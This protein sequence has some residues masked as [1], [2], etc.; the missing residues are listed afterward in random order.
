MPFKWRR[1]WFKE[2]YGSYRG[3]ADRRFMGRC[4]KLAALHQ[5][6]KIDTG[7]SKRK[8]HHTGKAGRPPLAQ[9]L[10]KELFRWFAGLRK[11]VKGRFPSKLLKQ[12]AEHLRHCAL[13]EAARLNVHVSLPEITSK[14]LTK[15]KK[16]FR[17]SLRKPCTFFKVP[18]NVFLERC[19][20]C[21]SNVYRARLFIM[22]HCGYD[23]EIEG[24]DQTPFHF[25]ESGSKSKA[26]LDFKGKKK[27]TLKECVSASRDRWTATTYT[28]SNPAGHPVPLEA[29]F[30]GG[31]GVLQSVQETLEAL[32]ASGRFGSLQNV[33]VNTSSSGSYTLPDVLAFLQRHLEP[34]TKNRRWKIL[35]CDAYKPH[36]CK[37]VRDLCWSRGYL[38]V[39][40]GG[41]C[42]G[43]QQVN[44]THLH[45][46]MSRT[47]Q[48][49][50][51]ELFIFAQEANP[52]G[53]KTMKREDCLRLLLIT[54]E[55]KSL[56]EDAS[57]GYQQ[58]LFTLP[59]DR[60][61]PDQVDFSAGSQQAQEIFRLCGMPEEVAV[62]THDLDD[63]F[64]AGRRPFTREAFE[65][66][67][68]EMPKRGHMDE[69]EDEFI[70]EG[71]A[72]KE[73]I[74]LWNDVQESESQHEEDETPQL[75]QSSVQAGFEKK[76]ISQLDASQAEEVDRWTKKIDATD[77]IIA[78]V[79][80]LGEPSL[81]ASA[82]RARRQLLQHASGKQQMDA[83]ISRAVRQNVDKSEARRKLM[84][85]ESLSRDAQRA[86]LCSAQQRLQEQQALIVRKER[87]FMDK[88]R[89]QKKK[90]AIQHAAMAWEVKDFSK[91]NDGAGSELRARKNRF[92]ALR[93]VLMLCDT[94]DPV[95]IAS[96]A[97][98]FHVWDRCQ[99]SRFHPSSSGGSH[100]THFSKIIQNI[101]AQ[102]QT[103]GHEAVSTWWEEQMNKF[104]PAPLILPAIVK[105]S[106][107]S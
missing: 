38:M 36:L 18:R 86:A 58:N 79:M 49:L 103:G 93:R 69:I 64:R 104:K 29:M 89:A 35:L 9:D 87:E 97:N 45:G 91:S 54:Y 62:I 8:R 63:D 19:R 68:E 47:Y 73:E 106:G 81:L 20:I 11:C 98:D 78:Q 67:M 100:A 30:K 51:M 24:F 4:L 2:R 96:F 99:E 46:P 22:H 42:T 90:E 92:D 85:E 56:H 57:R 94:L 39:Y 60:L 102:L 31:A 3:A 5:A 66:L 23:P 41:G 52:H 26:T 82:K 101:L 77:R 10:R 15:F 107:S 59:L 7:V 32:R 12:Q 88:L 1:P 50:E 25:N 43:A 75:P 80:E 34:W 71:S 72:D 6:G 17:I 84:Q 65:A 40:I 105:A 55:P 13:L 53:L 37:E 74:D 28:K 33:S 44:D 48:E 21:W 14:W 27:I 70:E 16:D 61:K 95:R 76:G 83:R